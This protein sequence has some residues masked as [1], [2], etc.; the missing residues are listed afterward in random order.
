ML[1]VRSQSYP[2]SSECSPSYAGT[3]AVAAGAAAAAAAARRAGTGAAAAAAVAAAAA[4]RAG[5]AAATVAVVAAPTAS[6]SAAA[7]GASAPAVTA[8]EQT[9]P[10]STRAT[11]YLIPAVIS[12]SLP[13]KHALATTIALKME[14]E[15]VLPPLIANP[16]PAFVREYIS[17]PGMCEFASCPEVHLAAAPTHHDNRVRGV[18]V[19]RQ[20]HP[21]T[22]SG[23]R[24]GPSGVRRNSVEG[25]PSGARRGPSGARWGSVGVPSGI[26]RGPVGDQSGARRTAAL[27]HKLLYI[28]NGR[29]DHV[30]ATLSFQVNTTLRLGTP[31]GR[32][33]RNADSRVLTLM[34]AVRPDISLPQ[35]HVVGRGWCGTT[36]VDHERVLFRAPGCSVVLRSALWCS[37]VFCGA[38][39]CSAAFRGVPY[40]RRGSTPL[41]DPACASRSSPQG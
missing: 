30:D 40:A 26:R 39:W 28:T 17:N 32:D 35:M 20:G 37:V 34:S 11:P 41:P 38:Q 23:A 25:T 29:H 7:A 36:G 2:I 33:S 14:E 21:G 15:N 16:T 18:P 13:E 5:A 12:Q 24:R 1:P 6:A 22:P 4:H 3:G 19:L 10:R 9:R 27:P 8:Q 31:M